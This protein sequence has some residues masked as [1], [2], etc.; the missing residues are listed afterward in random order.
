MIRFFALSLA[1]TACSEV[2]EPAPD[3]A[4]FV[5]ALV[6]TPDGL[7]LV[8]A[9]PPAWIPTFEVGAAYAGQPLDVL[10]S[11]VPQGTRAY[12]LKS[13]TGPGAGPCHPQYPI[14][15]NLRTP[16]AVVASGVAGPS[17]EAALVYSVPAN[18]AAPLWLQ[19]ALVVPATG[20]ARVTQVE[21]RVPGDADG[22]FILDNLDNCPDA[23]NGLQ[24][25]ADQDGYGAACDCVDTNALVHPGAV[26]IPS[27][28]I[29]D[30]CV[31]GD[32]N[33]WPGLYQ[34]TADFQVMVPFFPSS[35]PGHFSADVLPN[36]SVVG[37]GS[38]TN[39]FVGTLQF[40]IVGTWTGSLTDGTLIGNGGLQ[41]AYS[42][43]FA[44]LNGVATLN[45]DASGDYS[46]FQATGHLTGT[47]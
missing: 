9:P 26:E 12:L 28:G 41:M 11:G 20:D 27:N 32:Q 29:D 45:A 10:V 35:C 42:G 30:D 3:A 7:P 43:A 34:G 5:D 17:G 14:C 37:N 8:Q 6:Q 21:L 4:A 19:A 23:A 44:M 13:E 24:I 25:D 38:C 16:M 33:P 18:Q 40:D 2:T 15:A 31:G 47:R 1:L 46:G 22:D 39:G 36:G